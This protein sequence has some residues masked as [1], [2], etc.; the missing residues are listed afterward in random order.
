MARSWSMRC[1]S[2]RRAQAARLRKSQSSRRTSDRNDSGREYT[3]E[4][5]HLN[6]LLNCEE[7]DEERDQAPTEPCTCE[8][9]SVGAVA[10]GAVRTVDYHELGPLSWYH[11]VGQCAASPTVEHKPRGCEAR[12]RK[13]ESVRS[14]NQR[15]HG[16]RSCVDR[17]TIGAHPAPEPARPGIH[18]RAF[19]GCPRTGDGGLRLRLHWGHGELCLA[20]A[21][22][23][24]SKPR[25]RSRQVRR[26]PRRRAAASPLLVRTEVCSGILSR[27]SRRARW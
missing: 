21:I 25:I 26:T 4:W 18:G 23:S 14:P 3:D 9:G 27:P 10:D 8:C 6:E 13:S 20:G 12:G 19:Q 16:C 24:S 5:K 7:L 11:T 15:P 2:H 17:G 22:Q 1:L